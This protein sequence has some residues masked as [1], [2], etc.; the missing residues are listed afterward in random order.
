MAVAAGLAIV[1]VFVLGVVWKQRGSTP[2]LVGEITNVRTLG[3][4]ESASVAIVDF[5]FVNDSKLLFIVH[6]TGM[7]VTDSVGRVHEGR[8]LSASHTNE[9]FTLFPAL[10]AKAADT[11]IMKTRLGAGDSRQA[12]LAA[13]FEISKAQL[14]ARQKISLSVQE[15]DGAVSELSR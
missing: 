13:R 9:L 11:L 15:V 5:R 10:G 4:E 6:G 14:D 8:I 2:R 12:M 1:L 3:V 7:T